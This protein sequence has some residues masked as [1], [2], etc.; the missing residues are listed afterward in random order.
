MILFMQEKN[1]FT[2]KSEQIAEPAIHTSNGSGE[3]GR[4]ASS[5]RIE[6]TSKSSSKKRNRGSSTSL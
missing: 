5:S 4:S 6:S 3:T 1:E 2:E